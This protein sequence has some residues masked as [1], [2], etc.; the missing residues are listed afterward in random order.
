MTQPTGTMRKLHFP[1]NLSEDMESVVGSESIVNIDLSNWSN[2]D[3]DVPVPIIMNLSLNEYVA[4]A[5]AIDVGR[6]IAYGDNSIFIWW[7]WVRS[8]ESMTICQA[9]LDCINNT[10]ALHASDCSIFADFSITETTP[11]QQTI[12]DTDLFESQSPCSNDQIYGM[13]VQLTDFLNQ[14][15]EDILEIFVTAFA[16]PGR[17]GD[18]IEAIPVIGELPGD[19]ILQMLEKLATQV[20]DAYQAAYDTQIAEDI[21]CDL[22]CIAISNNCTLT[23]EDARD[24]FKNKLLVAVSDADFLSIANDIIANNWLGEQSVYVI[25]WMILDTIIFG[26]EMLGIDVNRMV[27]TISSFYNDPDPDWATLCSTCAWTSTLD[28]TISDYGFVFGIFS[29]GVAGE[30]QAGVGLVALPIDTGASLRRQVSGEI[31]FDDATIDSLAMFGTVTKGSVAVQSSPSSVIRFEQNQSTVAGTQIVEPFSAYPQGVP[32]A[33]NLQSNGYS[34][35]ANSLFF[36][37][38]IFRRRTRWNC[39]YNIGYRHWNWG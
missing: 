17:L 11:E 36:A 5:S 29:V 39:N 24:Y 20:N 22:F 1:L 12:L 16:A 26:G 18:I 14:V 27:T 9:I 6:D 37:Y 25:H 19:D 21:S 2:A 4:L 3:P 31:S 10:P 28:F 23:L 7:L 34:E 38:D 33:V 13:T 35:T 30:W 15:S 8:L 32:T